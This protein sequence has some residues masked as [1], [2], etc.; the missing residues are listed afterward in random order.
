DEALR[1]CRARAARPRRTAFHGQHFFV[2]QAYARLEQCMRD[3]SGSNL[4][5]LS[6]ALSALREISR[7][8]TIRAHYLVIRA[9]W[10]RLNGRARPA[11]RQLLASEE[12]ILESDN[13]W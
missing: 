6:E 12:A 5:R 7:H 9:A 10:E 13:I 8:P 1:E 11:L 4:R 3:A 2:F